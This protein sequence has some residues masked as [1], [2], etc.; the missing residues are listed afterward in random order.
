MYQ[1]SDRTSVIGPSAAGVHPY[2]LG[3]LWPCLVTLA[4]IGVLLLLLPCTRKS[5]ERKKKPTGAD[6]IGC[7]KPEVLRGC[8]PLVRDL[9]ISILRQIFPTQESDQGLL[10]CRQILSQ[11]SY[12]GS[13]GKLL[14]QFIC[15]SYKGLKLF[16]KNSRFCLQNQMQL[17]NQSIQTTEALQFAFSNCSQWGGR[18]GLGRRKMPCEGTWLAEQMKQ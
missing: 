8:L 18:W 10:H 13:P 12:Q 16:C 2:S 4:C 5:L 11:L 7:S 15:L 17:W 1:V 3:F 9:W 6:L 14:C